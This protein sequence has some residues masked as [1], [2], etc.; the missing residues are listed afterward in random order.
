MQDTA[1][2][3]MCLTPINLQVKR[4]NAPAHSPVHSSLR[5]AAVTPT[6]PPYGGLLS[7]AA[8]C[9]QG[10]Q[11]PAAAA[12]DELYNLPSSCSAQSGHD[13][14]ALGSPSSN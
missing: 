9:Q 3:I 12:A 13:H 10:D 2:H 11:A 14:A 1:K 4:N 6:A 5:C 7:S 8:A